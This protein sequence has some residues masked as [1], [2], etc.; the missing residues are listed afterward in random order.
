[1]LLGLK[2]DLKNVVS[3]QYTSKL[4]RQNEGYNG[5]VQLKWIL[6]WIPV[7]AL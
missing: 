3:K 5:A 1:M 6:L 2:K 4:H 7:E